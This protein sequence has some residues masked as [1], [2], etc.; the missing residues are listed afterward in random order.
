MLM[1]ML[2]HTTFGH[3]MGLHTTF[4]H[5]MGLLMLLWD[6]TRP[7]DNKFAST[8]TDLEEIHQQFLQDL[9]L[10]EDGSFPEDGFMKKQ[11]AVSYLN[12]LFHHLRRVHLIQLRTHTPTTS[13]AA[14]GMSMIPP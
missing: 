8:I 4:G 3:I 2:M 10:P 14:G 9:F 13:A 6:C 7:L 1:L 5:I 11:R 12:I